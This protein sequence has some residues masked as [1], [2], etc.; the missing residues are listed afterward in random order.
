MTFLLGKNEGGWM[1]SL[2]WKH[3]TSFSSQEGAKKKSKKGPQ[4]LTAFL[5]ERFGRLEH[6]WNQWV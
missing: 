1:I 6:S 3:C 2:P 5:T 4:E